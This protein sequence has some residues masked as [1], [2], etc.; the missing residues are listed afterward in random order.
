M[1]VGVLGPLQV[2]GQAGPIPLPSAKPRAVL[3]ALALRPGTS[4]SVGELIAALWG[5]DP[6]RSAEK[7][8]QVYVSQLR[9]AL[10]SGTITTVAGAYVLAVEPDHVDA[11]RFEELV[12]R[13]RVLSKTGDPEQAV[14]VLGEALGLWR[15]RPLADVADQAVGQAEAVRLEE[16][17]RGAEEDLVEARLALGQHREVVA[18]L[19][20][21][22][23]AEPLRER[24]W[25]LLML[26]L[27]RSGRQGE[28]LRA[29]TRMSKLLVEEL[30]IEPSGQLRQLETDIL[31]QALWLQGG[32]GPQPSETARLGGP[33]GLPTVV[34]GSSHARSEPSPRRLPA[35]LLV[36]AQR[37]LIGRDTE[38][39]RLQR[40]VQGNPDRVGV[41][42]VVGEPGVGKTRLVAAAAQSALDSGGRVLFGRC[43]EGLQ[44]P[45][46][47]FVEAF[48]SYVDEVTTDELVAQLGPTGPE[49]TRL[50]PSLA[51]RVPTLGAP[52]EGPPESERWYLFQAV[53][54]FL[55]SL[56]DGRRAV[57][58]IDDLQWAEP[59]TLL[60]LRHVARA[61]IDRLVIVATARTATVAQAGPLAEALADL[62]GRHLVDT[63]LLDGLSEDETEALLADRLN[64][65]PSREFV[66]AVHAQTGG[67]AFFVHELTSHLSDLGMLRGADWPTAWQVERSG[68]PE[69]VRHVLSSRLAQLSPSAGAALVVAAVAGSEFNTREVA[70]AL[71]GELDGVITALEEAAASGLIAENGPTAGGYRFAHALV[72][73]SL[74]E[75]VSTLRRA[76]L[77]WRVGEAIRA[78]AGPQAAGRLNELAYHYRQGL[79]AGEPAIVLG[80]LQRAGEQAAYQL[81]FEEAMDHYQTALA[82]LDRCPD[83]PNRRYQLLAGMAESAGALA[84]YAVSSKA[85]LAAADLAESAKDP[86]RFGRAVQGYGELMM[87]GASDETFL[88][89]MDQGL[90]L[91]DSG[92]SVERARLLALRAFFD[93]DF[94]RREETIRE[95]LAMA[96]RLN[97]RAAE[98]NVLASLGS[99]LLGS[100]R[101][102]ERLAIHQRELELISEHGREH[103]A[104]WT[105]AFAYRDAALAA[106]QLGRRSEAEG[107]LQRGETLA[108]AHNR[109]LVLHDV[110][111][112]DAA[113][114]IA[115][116]RFGEAKPLVAQT[117]DVGDPHNLAVALGYSA[118][119]AAIRA[120]QGRAVEVVDG[121]KDLAEHDGPATVAWRTMLAALCADL[122]RR[123]EAAEQLEALAPDNFAVIPRDWAFPLAIRYLAET[124]GQ[125]G[126]TRRAAQLLLEVEPYRGQ[127]L[128]ATLGTSIEASADRSLG[129]LYGVLGRSDD[130]DQ[131][132]QAA[133]RL[134]TSMGFAPLAARTRYWHARLLA[135][136]TSADD[137]SQALSHLAET[138]AT[139]STLGMALLE[140][141]ARQLQYRL[142]DPHDHQPPPAD[143]DSID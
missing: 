135:Q 32:H 131:H 118:Q 115:E 69:G 48:S 139:A 35:D 101:A 55:R 89:L 59:A 40:T 76:Q 93:R 103:G 136:S 95:A 109:R 112:I 94:P 31:N 129:Q 142:V 5:Q 116:G 57:M 121:L 119:V 72:R 120:E 123:D 19:E 28:A 133:Y 67:N 91:A 122:G 132:F 106:L 81:A 52:K 61:A 12:R 46:Q 16:L 110:L 99:L 105:N 85:W 107:A 49:L 102:E 9:R 18:D 27:Y 111:M 125:L 36:V 1:E 65:Q 47:P 104:D 128:V 6:P 90:Q 88:R 14:A 37:S 50:I 22:V 25:A 41:V 45:Y 143:P 10:P 75:R 140:H 68:T 113:I 73:H 42:M 78:A 100:A 66:A 33:V 34:G 79:E 58:V 71:G 51:E 80:W 30:G 38:L 134:E 26:A 70:L 29:F 7:L 87:L 17:R 44:A 96:H 3:T 60:M 4:V 13:A 137:R 108:R 2:L 62:A 43:D 98:A 21:A 141:Q 86:A 97:D 124:C 138:Q 74:Y 117:R 84:D 63:V 39:G 64:R 24:R 53:A 23:Q 82:A 126:D 11:G 8:V 114:A 54:S 15:G 92:D 20:V 127:L 130:A 77:H 56:S 83:D